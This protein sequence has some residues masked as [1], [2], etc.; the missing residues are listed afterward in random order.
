MKKIIILTLIISPLFTYS[1]AN[2]IYRKAIRTTD[3]K[4]RIKLFTEVIKL[5]PKN[6]D[7]YFYRGIS[8]NDLGDYN[9]AIIDYSKAFLYSLSAR[10][11]AALMLKTLV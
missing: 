6:F 5:E 7:A 8:K 3:L 10:Y 9:G 1:Q 4:E 11:A 2:K